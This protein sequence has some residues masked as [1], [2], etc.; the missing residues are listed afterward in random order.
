M[1]ASL[2]T[3]DAN[4]L[5]AWPDDRT[6]IG[7]PSRCRVQTIIHPQTKDMAVFVGNPTE[8]HRHGI[9]GDL[10][11]Y[12]PRGGSVVIECAEE[13]SWD[14]GDSLIRVTLDLRPTGRH[15]DPG[16]VFARV[17]KLLEDSSEFDL[18]AGE[19]KHTPEFEGSGQHSK[20]SDCTLHG[21]TLCCLYCGVDHS[22]E[23]LDCGGR[24]FHKG[25]CP[26]KVGAH[27]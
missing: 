20:D 24:G 14:G 23:C 16:S 2:F 18:I 26:T 15:T 1:S 12:I 22:E 3:R 25:N 7:I 13:L 10:H 9:D 17:Q 4:G 8:M 11:L 5:Q 21:Q 27:A 19:A 6:T